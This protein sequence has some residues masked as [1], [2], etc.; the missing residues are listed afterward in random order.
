MAVGEVVTFRILDTERATRFYCDQLGFALDWIWRPGE[1]LPAL[2]SISRDGFSLFL[3]EYP[4]CECGGL[5]SLF[6]DDIETW[7]KELMGNGVHLDYCAQEQPWG[8]KEAQVSDP[9]GNKLRLTQAVA[10]PS[11]PAPAST[12]VAKLPTETT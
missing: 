2:M 10:P 6:V 3:T 7:C 11:V 5:V 8:L 4:E 9:F 12:A 1:E